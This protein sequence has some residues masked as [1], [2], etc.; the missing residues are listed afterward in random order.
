MIKGSKG[1]TLLELIVAIA[2]IG[3][4]AGLALPAFDNQIKDARLVSNTNLVVGAYNFA[5][6]EAINRGTQIKVIDTANGWAVTTIASAGPPAVAQQILKEFAPEQTGI[7]W[8]PVAFPDVIYNS[9]GFRP[10]GSAA[11]VLSLTD[12][13]G[14]GRT[15]TISPV[16]STSVV[17]IP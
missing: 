1:V 3:I 16:G 15:I 12:S 7:T 5:R 11:V 9:S 2:I 13:R 4:L 10:F 14:T 6:S 8:A 17:K